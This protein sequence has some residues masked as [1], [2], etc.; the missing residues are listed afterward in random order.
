MSYRD[1]ML[2]PDGDP[3]DWAAV[4]LRKLREVRGLTILDVAEII[5]KTKSLVSKVENGVSPLQEEHAVKID[6]ACQTGGTL[7]RI[8]RTGKARHSSTWRAQVDALAMESTQA[9]VW[10]LGWIPTLLQTPEYAR[11][12]F[13]SAGRTD[14]DQAVQR[15]VKLQESI[16]ARKPMPNVRIIMDEG[17]LT[18]P[19]G[20]PD[21]WREQLGHLIAMAET[22][23]VRVVELSAGA[24]IGR[25]GSFVIYTAPDG[26]DY[27]F[28][29][30]VGPGRLIREP[31]EV[32]TYCAA[33]DRVSDVALSMRES[34][35]RLHRAR[36][37]AN[38]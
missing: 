11:A 9:R 7:A 4:E 10:S 28:T 31:G 32:A 19:V 29:S 14:L 30:T 16:L 21:V 26:R 27:P 18:M 25:D 15:R 36:E 12:S 33:F 1:R 13:V 22:V 3:F 17:A 23:T 24:H 35:V 38:A 20:A 37:Q 6:E 34:L 5:G 8:V 2:D